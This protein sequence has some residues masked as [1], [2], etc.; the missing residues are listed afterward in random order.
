MKQEHYQLSQEAHECTNSIP[1]MN[2]MVDGVQAL[3]KDQI[4]MSFISYLTSIICYL[5][6]L[7]TVAQCEDLK[8]KY[9]EEMAK[10][11]KLYNQVQDSKGMCL[12]VSLFHS[13]KH[14]LIYI[15]LAG[16]VQSFVLAMAGNIRVFCRCRPLSKEE[17]ASDY[18]TVVDFEGA[19]DGDLGIMAGGSTKKLFKFDRVFTPK[20]NQ[21]KHLCTVILNGNKIELYSF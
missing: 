9:S 4:K 7:L 11:K 16:A 17:I 13:I 3:G 6:M 10:R 19:K 1:N 2:K 5:I 12:F 15:Q 8:M 18:T 14:F 20:D 21:G